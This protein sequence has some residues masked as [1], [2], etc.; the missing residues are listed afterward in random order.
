M[1]TQPPADPQIVPPAPPPGPAKRCGLAIASLVCGILSLPTVGLGAILA[2][3]LGIV[4]LVKISKSHGA[5]GG[6]GMAIAGI[7]LGGL[8]F[9]ALPFIGLMAAIIAPAFMSAR[10]MAQSAM[11]MNNLKQ[12]SMAAQVY[13]VERDGAL[14]SPDRWPQE[15]EQFYGSDQVLKNPANPDAGRGYAMN[16]ALGGMRLDSIP[17]AARTVLFF[18]CAPG[19]PPSG[20]PGL[21]PTPPRHSRG[22]NIAFCDGHVEVVSPDDLDRLIWDP[23]K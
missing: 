1:S 14:P 8:F 23:K 15:L 2:V 9:L 3:I 11:S 17:E 16:A 18:E 22:H 21:L 20:G 19:A 12:L 7:V 6:K 4:G 10:G 13:A 5:L